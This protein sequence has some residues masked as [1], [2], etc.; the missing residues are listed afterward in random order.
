MRA[1]LLSIG[2][3]LLLGQIVDTNAT[4]LATRLAEIGVGLYFET[5]VGDNPA[6]MEQAFR[7]ALERSDTLIC[8]GGLGPTGD[9]LTTEVVATV[10]GRPLVLH[11]P[12]L[13]HIE[14]LYRQRNIPTYAVEGIRKQATIPQGALPIPNPVGSAAGYIVEFDG[15]LIATM[16]GVPAEM[17]A[18]AEQTLLPYLAAR[19]GGGTVIK[20]RVLK[21]VGLGESGVEARTRDLFAASRNPSI[22]Y[23]AKPG[24]AH[25]RITARADS[26]AEADRLIEGLEQQVRDRLADACYGVDDDTLEAAAGRLLKEQGLTLATAESCTGGLVGDRLTNVPGSSAYYQGGVVSYSNQAKIDLLGVPAATIE[27]HGAVSAETAAAMAQGARERLHAD[28]AVAITGIAGPTGGTPTKPVGLVHMALAH[29]AGVTGACHR[30]GGS[31]RDV[32][33]RAAQVAL[34]MLWQHLRGE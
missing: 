11:Q 19:A 10:T 7:Q 21:C 24:E 18:M 17:H 23:L 4:W 29:P 27:Q 25:L 2:T 32:K 12:S 34:T 3:E 31:R 1:E 33:E 14:Q 20:S 6:R 26:P 28:V 5:T 30:F 22:A 13:E 8:T 15:K 9:D 16:P